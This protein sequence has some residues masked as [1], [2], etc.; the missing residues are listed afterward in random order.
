MTT[1]SWTDL[2]LNTPAH[3]IDWS[4]FT[5]PDVSY[6][7]TMTTPGSSLGV[8]LND[9]ATQ[10]ALDEARYKTML[11]TRLGTDPEAMLAR[12]KATGVYDKW[13]AHSS[14][15]AAVNWHEQTN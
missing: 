1:P 11:S 4:K 15:V 7:Q 13:V 12:D 6:S 2:D 14:I 3:K 5:V 10:A 8:K 9:T